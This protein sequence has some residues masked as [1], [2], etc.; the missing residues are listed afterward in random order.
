MEI[1]EILQAQYNSTEELYS[2]LSNEEFKATLNELVSSN[3]TKYNNLEGELKGIDCPKCKNK[4]NIAIAITI[5]D[6]LQEQIKECDCI[7]TRRSL[8][9]LEDSGLKELVVNYKFSTYKT[10]SDWQS[11]I[12]EKAKSFITNKGNCFFIGGQI[13]AGKT[14]ICT[15]ICL[16]YIKQGLDTRYMLWRDEVMS[17]KL[18]MTDNYSERLDELKRV[19]VLYIDDF[20]KIKTGEQP[21]TSDVNIAFEIINHRYNNKGLI[22]IISSEKTM[23]DLL[24]LDEAIGSR[25]YQMAKNYTIDI[26]KD[27]SK[28]YRLRQ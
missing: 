9:R 15:A 1:K 6:L 19:K 17:I 4:G 24:K 21:T 26:H 16:N 11:Q 14:H 8:E 2:K 20:F 13:G 12:L 7:K 5:N 23:N 27:P 3:I 25:V 10:E 28:N 18:N 22:T